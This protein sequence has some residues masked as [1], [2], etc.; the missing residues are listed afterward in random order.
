MYYFADEHCLSIT[1]CLILL[2]GHA[3]ICHIVR[4][5]S[6]KQ[7]QRIIT[8]TVGGVEL[9]DLCPT[10]EFTGADSAAKKLLG[11][12]CR[13]LLTDQKDTKRKRNEHAPGLMV[14]L[15]KVCLRING[16]Q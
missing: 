8:N 15:A 5:L 13:T 4:T 11:E 7:M 14:D 6:T 10:F 2:Q 3:D 16:N 1:N 12:K 9:E